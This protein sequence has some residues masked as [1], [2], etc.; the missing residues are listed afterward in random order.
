MT[1]H[2]I[3]MNLIGNN[4]SLTLDVLHDIY[5]LLIHN[6]KLSKENKISFQHTLCPNFMLET[7]C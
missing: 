6:I 5:E 2:F 1:M 4:K 3:V 7:K